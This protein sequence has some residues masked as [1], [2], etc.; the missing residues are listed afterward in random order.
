M[1]RTIAIGTARLQRYQKVIRFA[2]ERTTPARI[3]AAI[4]AAC[5]SFEAYAH[6]PMDKGR[7]GD[8]SLLVDQSNLVFIG[9]VEKVADER[10]DSIIQ[11]CPTCEF[12]YLVAT[13]WTAAAMP[14]FGGLG[15]DSSLSSNLT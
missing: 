4:A 1:S 9:K 2:S 13:A 6:S 8:L 10:Y 15:R 12:P 7:G 11:E 5:V 3:L 14:A